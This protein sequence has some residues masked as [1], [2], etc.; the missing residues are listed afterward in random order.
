[1]PS[2]KAADGVRHQ[3]LCADCVGTGLLRALQQGKAVGSTYLCLSSG[4]S[5][6]AAASPQNSSWVVAY[7]IKIGW[8][9]GTWRLSSRVACIFLKRQQQK[10]ASKL[11]E[12]IYPMQVVFKPWQGH[13]CVP[14]HVW[15][16]M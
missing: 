6:R 9:Q 12:Q 16:G 5:L 13:V 4:V 3:D 1:M 8:M 10:A 7:P 14:Q 15:A 11:G 2:L